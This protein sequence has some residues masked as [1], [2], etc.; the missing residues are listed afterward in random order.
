[1]KAA[2]ET[3]P[4]R[5]EA[6]GSF[7]VGGRPVTVDGEPLRSIEMSR[8]VPA[9]V[10][11]PNGTYA[12][13]HAYVSYVIP[14]DTSRMPVV[15]VH[16]GG[17]TGACWETTPDG[18]PGWLTSF[19]RAGWPCYVIDNVERGRAGWCSLP[20]FRSGEPILRSEQEC[21]TSFRIGPEAGYKERTAFPGS[22]FPVDALASLTRQ[23]VPRW[24]TTGEPSVAA[25]RAAV[26]QIGRCALI[27]HSQGGGFA[28]R[29]ASAAP[30]T[31]L[32]TVLLEPHGLP[33][34]AVGPQLLVVG[35][36]IECSEITAQ[37]APVW[38]QYS[39]T[40]P[41]VDVMDL[42]SL[43]H[44]GNSHLMMADL[45][46]EAVAALIREWLEKAMTDRA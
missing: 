27:G 8:D 24:T 43:G 28:A 25:L 22:A 42:P 23:M 5:I 45:N 39:A 1:M 30:N 32:A 4:M 35:D 29:V 44:R 37:L 14:A 21:W 11:D 18:R 12:I 17:M 6:M 13:D 36:N 2:A 34:E 3:P 41:Q 46:S 26:E 10:F 38:T 40:S 33:A 7:F 20:G 31:V 9:Y 19:L 15:F 16:G